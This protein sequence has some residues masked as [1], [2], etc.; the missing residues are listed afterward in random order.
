MFPDMNQ[1]RISSLVDEV[2]VNRQILQDD[3]LRVSEPLRVFHRIW[4]A[5]GH[6]GSI[7]LGSDVELPGGTH[8]QYMI[9]ISDHFRMNPVSYIGAGINSAFLVGTVGNISEH[10][11]AHFGRFWRKP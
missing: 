1:N 10:S 7:S 3:D 8:D 5:Q 2:D 4:N 11:E 9:N 6:G